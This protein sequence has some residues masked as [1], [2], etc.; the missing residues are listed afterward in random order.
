[1]HKVKQVKYLKDYVLL[2]TFEDNKVKEVDIEKLRSSGWKGVFAP[3]KDINT[4]KRVKIVGS[5][6]Q[7]PGEVDIC[8]D[9]LYEIGKEVN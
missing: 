8:P 2:L 7:W 6:I 4:F 9:T 1:M 5:T 3:L